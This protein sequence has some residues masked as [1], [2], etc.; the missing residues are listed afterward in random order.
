MLVKQIIQ[1]ASRFFAPYDEL[2]SQGEYEYFKSLSWRGRRAY[3]GKRKQRICDVWVNP[4][5]DIPYQGTGNQPFTEPIE[6]TVAD[7]TQI[8]NTV[9]ETIVAPDLVIGARTMQST[10]CLR[11]W[12]FGVNSNVVTTPGTLTFRIRWGGVAGT[13]LLQSAAQG[14]DT[15]AHTNALW[16]IMAYITCRTSGSSGTFLSGGNLNV[17]N[18]LASTAA[19]LLPALMGSAGTPGTSGNAAVTVDTTAD[20]N[21]S[22]TAQFSVATSPTNLTCQQRVIEMVN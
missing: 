12:A 9:T 16:S 4:N 1:S 7:G 2:I 18:V 15:T 5:P 19:N 20:K 22:V 10:R 14:L 13:V 6:I 17:F 8:S 3:L 11:V 21:L